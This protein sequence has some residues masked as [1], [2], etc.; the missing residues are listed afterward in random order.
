MHT[1]PPPAIDNAMSRGKLSEREDHPENNLLLTI[2]EIA[3]E[4][5]L[6]PP[7]LRKRYSQT[8]AIF[9]LSPVKLPNR[10]LR[11]PADAFEQLNN[12]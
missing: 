5:G 7:S 9:R 12:G 6:K 4:L 11:C 1:N 10:D 2:E 3:A 8:E